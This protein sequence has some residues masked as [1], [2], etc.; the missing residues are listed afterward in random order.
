MLSFC[1]HEPWK[2]TTIQANHSCVQITSAGTETGTT[3]WYKLVQ[4]GT[5]VWMFSVPFGDAASLFLEFLIPELH[6][7]TW[8][9][10]HKT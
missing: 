8:E 3:I 10:D 6:C 1:L 4:T 5:T 2:I 9:T 7:M